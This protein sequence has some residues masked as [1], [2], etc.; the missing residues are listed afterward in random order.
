[1]NMYER[2]GFET[3]MNQQA[4][5]G[6]ASSLTVLPGVGSFDEGMRRLGS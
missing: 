4:N 1:M 5:E 3:T 2:I 6:R